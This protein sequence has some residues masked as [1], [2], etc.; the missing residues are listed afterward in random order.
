MY[1]S[2][3]TPTSI[4]SITSH[5]QTAQLAQQNDHQATLRAQEKHMISLAIN[6]QVSPQYRQHRATLNNARKQRYE[7]LHE[8]T[9]IKREEDN[10]LIMM[11]GSPEVLMMDQVLEEGEGSAAAL[12]EDV[13]PSSSA[14][15]EKQSS[16]GSYVVT[17][18]RKPLQ[19]QQQ[20][21]GQ[22]GRISIMMAES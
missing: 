9:V 5:H 17:E 12:P 7:M 14:I 10:S 1:S 20:Q 16:N 18:R 11:N 22:Q 13:D 19:P 2:T 3:P 21:Q 6:M 15:L 8:K 4:T